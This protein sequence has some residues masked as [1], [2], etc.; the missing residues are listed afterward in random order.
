MEF[1]VIILYII[2][3][4]CKPYIKYVRVVSTVSNQ[5]KIFEN[6]K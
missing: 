6:N 5:G 3:S 1:I 2:K 4:T